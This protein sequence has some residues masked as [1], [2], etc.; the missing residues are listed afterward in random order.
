MEMR[1]SETIW[2]YNELADIPDEYI[3]IK[4]HIYYSNENAT[5]DGETINIS[6]NGTSSNKPLE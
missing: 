2:I 1:D 3:I 6:K 5:T 4:P